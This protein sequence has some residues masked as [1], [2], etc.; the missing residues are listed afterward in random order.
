MRYGKDASADTLEA[1]LSR[2]EEIKV[3]VSEYNRDDAFNMDETGLFYKLQPNHTLATKRLF[4][5]KK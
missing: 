3:F 1:V 5:N 4:R 2:I